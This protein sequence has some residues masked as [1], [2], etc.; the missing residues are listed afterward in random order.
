MI[1]S[2]WDG[3]WISRTAPQYDSASEALHQ[4][5]FGESARFFSDGQ[6]WNVRRRSTA[7]RN[8]HLYRRDGFLH[9][10]PAQAGARGERPLEKKRKRNFTG[11]WMWKGK[12]S[13]GRSA[14]KRRGAGSTGRHGKKRR[15]IM[16]VQGIYRGLYREEDTTGSRAAGGRTT[17]ITIVCWGPVVCVLRV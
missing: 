15:T 17:C 10:L 14:S 1:R 9:L 7:A 16:K 6:A 4:R 5:N 12:R 13:Q 2:D 11:K 8:G 3:R